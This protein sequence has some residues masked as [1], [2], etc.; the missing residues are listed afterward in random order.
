MFAA[1]EALLNP[2]FSMCGIIGL[3]PINKEALV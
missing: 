2:V 3:V 1:R